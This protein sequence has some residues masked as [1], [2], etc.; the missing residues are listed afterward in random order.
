M[1]YLFRLLVGLVCEIVALVPCAKE[2]WI[3]LVT[4]FGSTFNILP[5]YTPA[6]FVCWT[7]AS[8]KLCWAKTL[9]VSIAIFKPAFTIFD[10]P[11]ATGPLPSDMFAFKPPNNPPIKSLPLS[12][13]F[14]LPAPIKSPNEPPNAWAAIDL[15]V[16][17]TFWIFSFLGF[18]N[19][20]ST[21]EDILFW[22]NGSNLLAKPSTKSEPIL[23]K[24]PSC[25][26]FVGNISLCLFGAR[27]GKF[28][29]R[30]ELLLPSPSDTNL[31]KA[32]SLVLL[33]ILCLS[34]WKPGCKEP[35]IPNGEN[36][37]LSLLYTL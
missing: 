35:L 36:T 13:N 25:F 17:P 31:P 30:K 34:I 29:V 7:T 5:T 10:I 4:N 14:L 1:L 6:W 9:A 8:A 2:A 21:I 33:F 23:T 18:K 19:A 3:E 11:F 26:S 22:A 24:A 32:S 12:T 15:K 16:G 28:S 20:C 37:L 27:L